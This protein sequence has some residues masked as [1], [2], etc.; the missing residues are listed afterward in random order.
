MVDLLLRS[1]APVDSASNEEK[2]TP[3]HMACQSDE[4]NKDTVALL[5]KYGAPPGQSRP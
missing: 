1:D 2:N 5:L 3:L 4:D